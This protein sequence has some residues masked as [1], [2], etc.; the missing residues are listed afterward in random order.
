MLKRCFLAL[1]FGLILPV[2]AAADSEGSSYEYSMKSA[3]EKYIF[4]MLRGCN[5]GEDIHFY[6]SEKYPESGLYLNDGSAV[7]LWTVDWCG[8]VGQ[9]EAGGGVGSRPG[10]HLS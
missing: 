1:C 5:H 7:P 8:W 6:P 2:V 9:D 10:G 4:V 3:D